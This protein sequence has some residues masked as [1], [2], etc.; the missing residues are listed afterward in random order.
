MADLSVHGLSLILKDD[1][2]I[3]ATVKVEWG[4]SAHDGKLIYCK[5]HGREFLAGL[6][7][8][9]PVYEITRNTPH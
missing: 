7:V 2:P 5:P 8:E 9:D 6:K 3:G 1:L 4:E